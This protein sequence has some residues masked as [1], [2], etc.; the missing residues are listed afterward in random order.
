MTATTSVP[1]AALQGLRPHQLA[2][3]SGYY[4]RAALDCLARS[5]SCQVSADAAA[6]KVDARR[7]G[8]RAREYW[9]E[10]RRALAEQEA[11]P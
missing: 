10:F 3:W 11:R 7:Y 6:L 9:S 1:A 2:Y 4:A 8:V 5:R